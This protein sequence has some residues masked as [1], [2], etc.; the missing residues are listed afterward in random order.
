MPSVRA[1]V[2]PISGAWPHAVQRRLARFFRPDPKVLL[3]PDASSEDFRRA[4]SSIHVGSTIKITERDRHPAADQLLLDH[5][6]LTGASIVD[7]GASDGSTSVDLVR[8]LPAFAS[9]TAADLCLAVSAARALRH[10]VVYDSSGRCILVAGRWWAAWPSLSRT[11]RALC[12]PVEAAAARHPERR[13]Q[14]LLI[15]P[16]FRALMNADPRLSVRVHDVFTP[17]PDP[18]PDVIKVANLLR[19]VYF[20]DADID[21]ALDAVFDS[22]DEGGH[23]LVVD[24]GTQYTVPVEEDVGARAGLYRREGD[25]FTPVAQTPAPSEIADLLAKVRKHPRATA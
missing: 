21:R 7:I 15:N 1:P 6:D 24:D 12:W 19:R 5:L 20:S 23:L 14:V 10:V 17:W 8:R 2:R 11:V 18:A 9:Y 4:M 25:R 16:E 3:D 22:L 13:E